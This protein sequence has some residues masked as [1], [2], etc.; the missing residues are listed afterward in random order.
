MQKV[1]RFEAAFLDAD[2]T[3]FDSSDSLFYCTAY[4]IRTHLGYEITRGD[5]IRGAG[6]PFEESLWRV[7]QC[8]PREASNLRTHYIDYYHGNT[9]QISPFPGVAE[10]LEAFKRAGLKTAIVSTRGLASLI[11]LVQSNGFSELIDTIVGE[12]DVLELGRKLKPSPDPLYLAMERIGLYVPSRIAMVGDTDKDIL[13]GKA[14]GTYTVGV[15]YGHME[16]EIRNYSADNYVSSFP[17]VKPILI[18]QGVAVG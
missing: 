16:E 14:A 7:A 6:F 15:T 3:L 18:G 5:M 1:E 2:G 17:E 10:T 11:L 4:A 12:D 13:A 9:H 8:D